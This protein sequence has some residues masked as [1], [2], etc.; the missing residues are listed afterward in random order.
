MIGGISNLSFYYNPYQ[1]TAAK[2]AEQS[3]NAQRTGGV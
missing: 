1:S 3:Q 2:P